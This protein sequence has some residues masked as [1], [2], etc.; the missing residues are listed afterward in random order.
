[1]LYVYLALE[2]TYLQLNLRNGR[3]KR[4]LRTPLIVQNGLES[5]KHRGLNCR[6]T[7]A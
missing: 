7:L 2:A 3:S 4:S 5:P 6:V 1:M